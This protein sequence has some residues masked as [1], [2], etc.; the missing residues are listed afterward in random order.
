MQ[1]EHR[2]TEEKT[3]ERKLTESIRVETEKETTAAADGSRFSYVVTAD[4]KNMTVKM[5]LKKRMGFSSRLL[6]NMKR[7]GTVTR[8]G[9]EVRLFADVIE[10]DLIQAVLPEERSNFIPEDIPIE[11]VYED[12][13]MLII[14]KQPWVVVHPTKGHPTGTITNGLMKRMEDRGEHFKVR[15]VNRLDRDTSGLLIV[16]KNSHCQDT[17]TKQ[18]KSDD[19]EKRYYAVVHGVVEKDAG[20]IDLPIDRADPDD[21]RRCVIETGYPSVTHYKVVERFAA[22][23]TMVE[24]RLE[25]GRTHQIRVH[26]S[27]VGHPLV[28]DSLYGQEEP[29]LIER[30]ALHSYYLRFRHP[31][32]EEEREVKAGL[33]QDIKDLVEKLRKM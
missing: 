4:D 11:A 8:N 27:H 13:D 12:D 16:A 22:G 2:M 19:V 14:N 5:I 31:V 1:K 20:T 6:T 3:L 17:L 32:S 7:G 10:G 26:M 18:M 15:F 29:E 28:G 24:L 25:T 9:V 23:F 21:V 33:P 30:Q